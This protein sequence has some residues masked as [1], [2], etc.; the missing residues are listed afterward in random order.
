MCFV[1]WLIISMYC[2]LL[3]TLGFLW[4]PKHTGLGGKGQGPTVR[5]RPLHCGIVG[6]GAEQRLWRGG[7]TTGRTPRASLAKGRPNAEAQVSECTTTKTD[8][9][10][11]LHGGVRGGTL[12]QTEMPHLT[13][14]PAT[15]Q[16]PN[17]PHNHSSNPPVLF[18]L[19]K[20]KGKGTNQTKTR[21]PPDF[22][23]C[24]ACISGQACPP[25]TAAV[26]LNT[27]L[28]VGGANM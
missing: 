12:A 8:H 15:Q 18:F 26:C 10:Q 22:H 23:G 25:G 7:V 21:Q 2:T 5:P 11:S 28:V 9:S 4:G 19:Q 3:L 13:A 20:K 27:S 6:P 17:T 1:F 16:F 24:R 14:H